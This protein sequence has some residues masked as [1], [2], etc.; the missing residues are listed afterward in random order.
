MKKI[1]QPQPPKELVELQKWFSKAVV[2][3]D[4][5]LINSQRYK[6][7]VTKSSKQD[8]QERLN[9][10]TNDFWPRCIDSLADDFNLLKHYLG[11]EKFEALIK[12]YIQHYP[13]R[14]FT[15]YHLGQDLERY[16]CKSYTDPDKEFVNEL[17]RYEWAYMKAFMAKN[18]ASI[19]AKELTPQLAETLVQKVLTFHPSVSL[20]KLNYHVSEYI[21]S[22]TEAPEKGTQHLVVFRKE[23]KSLELK[24]S[25]TFFIVLTNIQEGRTIQHILESLPDTLTKTQLEDLENNIQSWFETCVR[26]DWFCQS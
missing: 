12:D 21:S 4:K 24:V 2:N 20:L 7:Y 22:S 18:T 8:S 23:F 10:Y 19:A 5:Q 26:Q 13:S 9:I 1:K 6:D 11:E 16:I 25:E 3:E 15:L 14:S 17:T